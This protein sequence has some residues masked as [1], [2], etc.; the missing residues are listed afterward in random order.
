MF[1]PGTRINA[2]QLTLEVKNSKTGKSKK[3]P[4]LNCLVWEESGKMYIHCLEFDL[5]SDG[6]NEANAIN[7]LIELIV[8][9]MRLADEESIQ[10]FHP[11]PKEYWDKLFEIHKNRLTQAFLES[12]PKSI[13]DIRVSEHHLTYA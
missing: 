5:I 12:K 11:A 13:K 9:Q 10:L 1:D 4:P 3:L 7:N 6:N 2:G 8:E